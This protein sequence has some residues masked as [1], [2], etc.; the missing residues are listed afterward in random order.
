MRRLSLT[1]LLLTFAM[2]SYGCA[3]VGPVPSCP[4]LKPA[5]A[6]LMQPSETEK[7]VRAELFEPQPN[8]TSK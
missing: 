2:S 8:A 7:K 4:K 6:S 1:L 5:P 3:T